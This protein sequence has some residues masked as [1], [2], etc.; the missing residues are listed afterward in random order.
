MSLDRG[1]AR[2]LLVAAMR[3][4]SRH[5]FAGSRV[6]RDL[7]SWRRL[8]LYARCFHGGNASRLGTAHVPRMD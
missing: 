7:A 1:R 5:V 2:R 3:R 6:V 4:R 8:G